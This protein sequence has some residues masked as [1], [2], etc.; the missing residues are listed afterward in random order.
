MKRIRRGLFKNTEQEHIN[1]KNGV[2]IHNIEITSDCNHSNNM[3]PIEDWLL[4]YDSKSRNQKKHNLEVFLEWLGKSASEVLELR[5]KDQNR[6]FEKL[7]IKYV[8]YLHEKKGFEVSTSVSKLGTVRAWF[9]Y[10]DLELK[11]K[12][13]ELPQVPLKPR[14]FGLTIDH[15]RSMW[16]YLSVW[17]RACSITGLENGLRISDVM[18]LE[19]SDVEN[20]LVQN[21]DYPSMEISTLKTG[22]LAK[23]HLSTEAQDII[24]VYLKTIPKNQERLFKKDVDTVSKMLQKAFKLA[25][26]DIDFQPT[27]KCFRQIFLS[28]GSN[29]GI[30]EWHLRYMCG[31]R[32][33]PDILVYL[34]NLDLKSDFIRIKSRLTIQPS[35]KIGNHEALESMQRSIANQQAEILDMK[36][37]L[38]SLTQQ[39]SL[40]KETVELLYPKK[41]ERHLLQ[42]DGTKK[43]WTEK[44]ETPEEYI[45]AEKQFIK[46]LLKAQKTSRRNPNENPE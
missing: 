12:K 14:K 15:V 38:E 37:R 36:T 45:E 3:N 46:K 35:I 41:V 9:K 13:N 27:F 19:K 21:I 5:K 30:N 29:L 22:A 2:L 18:A 26:P 42:D 20:M 10:H 17:M 31:K 40:L 11:F 33:S 32:V 24:K 7:C 44:F 25:Y 1:P 4:T 8:N 28:T 6:A 39:Y 23:I 43:V 16:D 34:R